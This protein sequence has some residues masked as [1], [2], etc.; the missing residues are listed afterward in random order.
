MNTLTRLQDWYG[1]Q[2]NGTWEHSWG[3]KIDTIDNPGW[4]VT[5]DLRQT[6]YEKIDFPKLERGDGDLDK[7]WIKC[8]TKDSSFRGIGDPS[9]LEEILDYFL[10]HIEASQAD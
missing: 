8:W 1:K 7:D 10:V 5:I 2:C 4:M 9:K 6:S 3:V